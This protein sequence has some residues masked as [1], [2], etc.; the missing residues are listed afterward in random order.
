MYYKTEIKI[1]FN[2]GCGIGDSGIKQISKQ[3]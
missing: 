1:N 2:S 3:F